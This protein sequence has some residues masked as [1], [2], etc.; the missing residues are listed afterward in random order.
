MPSA[1]ARYST[2]R[3]SSCSVDGRRRRAEVGALRCRGSAAQCVLGVDVDLGVQDVHAGEGA[4]LAEEQSST[5]PQMR[6]LAVGRRA[7]Q[8]RDGLGLAAAPPSSVTS[9]SG[10]AGARVQIGVTPWASAVVGVST[11]SSFSP[12]LRDGAP[13]PAP[14][15]RTAAVAVEPSMV[16]S[17]RVGAGGRRGSA[18]TGSRAAAG[19]RRGASTVTEV[20]TTVLGRRGSG[21]VSCSGPPERHDAVGV[22]EPERQ[23]LRRPA[24]WTPALKNRTSTVPPCRAAARHRRRPPAPPPRPPQPRPR[25]GQRP[26]P[27]NVRRDDV[28][29]GE[30]ISRRC[31]T[32]RHRRVT[33]NGRALRRSRTTAPRCS[34]CCATGSGSTR[35]RTAAAR[36]ASAVA[37]RSSSTGSPGSRA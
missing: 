29:A 20:A 36:R 4:L 16:S 1:S 6:R 15:S 19:P 30:P 21:T 2:A 32:G 25:R 35:P 14:G 17:S 31:V 18:R 28:T 3:R 5:G 7:D 27:R 13:W 24:A 34:R 37:A 26:R 23:A 8:Q 10:Q 11:G 33:V 12:G 22:A 9:W